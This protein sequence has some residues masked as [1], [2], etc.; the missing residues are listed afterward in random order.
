MAL[1]LVIA[2]GPT[3]PADSAGWTST[4][5]ATGSSGAGDESYTGTDPTGSGGPIDVDEAAC[6]EMCEAYAA[7]W[8]GADV[9]KCRNTCAGYW[10]QGYTDACRD[11]ATMSR[12]CL[13]TLTCAE[14]LGDY[15]N[16]DC[17]DELAV[18]GEHCYPG[19]CSVYGTLGIPY[20]E[21]GGAQGCSGLPARG[22]YCAGDTCTCTLDG[23]KGPSCEVPA[24]TCDRFPPAIIDF[25]ECCGF[26]P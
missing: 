24:D 2:C 15:Y 5:G 14:L 4:G 21:C 25:S 10:R 26:G 23:V 6:A 8:P 3:G 1:V 18:E 12:L 13:A 20:A 11:A 17:E 7:C 16:T 19:G 22:V 9:E